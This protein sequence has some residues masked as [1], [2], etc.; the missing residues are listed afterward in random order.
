MNK[1]KERQE[2]ALMYTLISNEEDAKKLPKPA[3]SSYDSD[4]MHNL[5]D[6]QVNMFRD[7]FNM[8]DKDGNNTID[9]S[10][11]KLILEE[12][13]YECST[14][15]VLQVI[16]KFDLNTTGTIDFNEFLSLIGDWMSND[17]NQIRD[18]FEVFDKEG[19]GYL[20]LEQLKR[21]LTTYGE[22]FTDNEAEEFFKEIDVDGDG[23][24]TA[25][26]FI[27]YIKGV[28]S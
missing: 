23:T 11:L 24:I 25:D 19:N 4:I 20:S 17:E 5:T 6:M 18:A 3:K 28:N 12:L 10:E 2:M 27:Q 7:I 26:E 1:K 16:S 9:C 14:E 8:Y 15:E 22:A 21:A 13:G